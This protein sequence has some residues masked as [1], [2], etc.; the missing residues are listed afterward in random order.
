MP[1]PGWL[2]NGSALSAKVG[3]CRD[4][5]LKE[6]YL[7]MSM[8]FAQLPE[9]GPAFDTL[10][11]SEI[12]ENLIRRQ[13]EAIQR[14]LDNFSVSARVDEVHSGPLETLFIIEPSAPRRRRRR[15]SSFSLQRIRSLVGDFSLALA[16]GDISVEPW[17][18]GEM[19][20][21]IRV[22]NAE[23]TTVC[24]RGVLESTAFARLTGC[25]RIGL[26]QDPYGRPIVADF[27]K[28][29]HV[30]IAGTTGSGKSVCVHSFVAA[31]L[32]QNTPK[33]L[34]FVM[35]DTKRVELACYNGIPHLL[36]PLV[37]EVEPALKVLGW[38]SEM[39]RRRFQILAE[40]AARDIDK[41]NERATEADGP[42]LPYTLVIVDEIADLAIQRPKELEDQL[43][44]LAQVG[45][46]TGIHLIVVTNRP[47][48]D[49]VARSV[50]DNF[51]SRI[52]FRVTSAVDSRIVLDC[53]GAERLFGCG[54]MLY[55]PSDAD[56]P[57]RVQGAFISY[58]ELDRLTSYWRQE[59]Q[60][61]S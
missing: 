53:K 36:E 10:P 47:S 13:V 57:M 51:P 6:G 35:V 26:G 23:R 31:L 22:P 19:G 15:K 28:M 29:P 24:L 48:V 16:S 55:L 40:N 56:E 41:F 20:V 2:T 18:E 30:L 38:V 37:I 8:Q 59:E 32:L 1:L 33:T 27:R 43:G 4:F 61:K 60:P 3:Q 54:D 45:R 58:R 14:T 44:Y 34:R 9:T 49:V 25:L 42:L 21:A 50:L 39:A 5:Q 52:A 12:D 17:Q 7:T 11:G 46:Q